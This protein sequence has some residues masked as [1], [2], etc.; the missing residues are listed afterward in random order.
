MASIRIK[1]A[2]GDNLRALSFGS[3]GGVGVST[4]PNMNP[5]VPGWY[6]VAELDAATDSGD[7]SIHGYSSVFIM[8]NGNWQSGQPSNFAAYITSGHNNIDPNITWL[9]SF[10]GTTYK[11]LRVGLVGTKRVIDLYNDYSG[12][13]AVGPYDVTVLE[14]GTRLK[15][16]NPAQIVAT[17]P[18]TIYFDV[19]IGEPYL[20]LYAA[21]RSTTRI[22]QII[23]NGAASNNYFIFGRVRVPSGGAPSGFT[24]LVSGASNFSSTP[25]GEYIVNVVGG[26]GAPKMHVEELTC[27]YTD[28]EPE[29]GYYFDS[30]ENVYY[31]GVK[32]KSYSA[33]PSVMELNRHNDSVGSYGVADY[34]NY[35]L[36]TL[37]ATWNAVNY[38]LYT[39][40]YRVMSG[41]IEDAGTGHAGTWILYTENGMVYMRVTIPKGTNYSTLTTI[42]TITEENYRPRADTPGIATAITGE[43]V[44]GAYRV[45]GVYIKTD[46]SIQ[47]ATNGATSGANVVTGMW[48]MHT[49]Y[50]QL[51]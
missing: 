25:S 20:A 48:P 51:A 31:I 46:G 34:G 13:G 6:R 3:H 28:Y 39:K 44:T 10:L 24:A 45:T 36:S 22:P 35:A 2:A 14:S 43:G 11:R 19:Q 40:K 47:I 15:V 7:E 5:S 50:N 49:V 32:T 1:D 33:R 37:P 30:T 8:G 26:S 21:N 42:G 12:S 27:T 29:F 16:F 38:L 23:K 9:K 17:D 18:S 4:I 41:K